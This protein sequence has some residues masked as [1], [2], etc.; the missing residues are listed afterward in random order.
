M[1]EN[2][3][4]ATKRYRLEVYRPQTADGRDRILYYKTRFMAWFNGQLASYIGVE[5]IVIV[6]TRRTDE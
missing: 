1:K 4:N 5:R 3:M 2:L 6:D